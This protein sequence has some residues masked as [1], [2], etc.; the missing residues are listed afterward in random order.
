M[1]ALVV[2]DD[3]TK[4]QAIT[5]LLE[6]APNSRGQNSVTV[7]ATLGNAVRVMSLDSFDLVVLDLMLPYVRGGQAD[8]R[9]GLE[10]LRQLR[11]EDGRTARTSRL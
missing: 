5:A 4:S 11:S 6:Q 2:D 3:K 7:V 8:S 1:K 10:V 9:A